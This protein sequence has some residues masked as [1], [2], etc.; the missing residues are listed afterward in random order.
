MKDEKAKKKIN[1]GWLT[2]LAV[3]ILA[4]VWI[5]FGPKDPGA[6]RQAFD[7]SFVPT[8]TPIPTALPASYP[9]LIREYFENDKAT[10]GVILGG[11]VLVIIVLLGVVISRRNNEK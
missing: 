1:W 5:L 7:S 8:A 11:A 2:L 3:V 9:H 10:Y 4:F 6:I